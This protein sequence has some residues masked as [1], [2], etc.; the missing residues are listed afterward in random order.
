MVPMSLGKV[1]SLFWYQ[2]KELGMGE[3]NG[4]LYWHKSQ[5][6]TRGKARLEV[7]RRKK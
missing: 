4:K 1:W 2:E 5:E 6:L 3:N 7:Y